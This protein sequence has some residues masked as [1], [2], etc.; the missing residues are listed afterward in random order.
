MSELDQYDYTLPKE[1]IAQHPLERR[2][3]ARLL[4]V[5][6]AEEAIEHLHIRDLPE[7]LAPGTPFHEQ[8]L[9]AVG[10]QQHQVSAW[11]HDDG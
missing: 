7:I 3:D 10:M 1:L 8:F 11:F 6:R 4:V 5:R 2:H 9:A